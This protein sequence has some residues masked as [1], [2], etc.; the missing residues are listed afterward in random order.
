MSASFIEAATI[1]ICP[2]PESKPKAQAH[3]PILLLHD[4]QIVTLMRIDGVQRRETWF[5][6]IL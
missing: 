1:R 6:Y 4:I 5:F 3:D 2:I